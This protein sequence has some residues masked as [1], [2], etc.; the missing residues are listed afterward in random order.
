MIHKDSITLPESYQRD[1]E[2]SLKKVLRI[3]GKFSWASFQ[4]LSVARRD[5]QYYVFDG[6]HRLA[7]ALRRSD[8]DLVPCLVFDSYSESEEAKMFIGL[9]TDRKAMDGA[10]RHKALVVQGDEI[11][12]KID[13]MVVAAGRRVSRTASKNTVRCVTNMRKMM[14]LDEESFV[15]VW[16]VIVDVCDGHPLHQAIAEGLFYIQRTTSAFYLPKWTSRAL[17]SGYATLLEGAKQGAAYLGAGGGKSW[18]DGILKVLNKGVR[19]KLELP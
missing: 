8:I 4:C 16:P 2:R 15:T 13:R 17:D 18:A 12:I 3:A 6:G 10:D 14:Q 7:A 5:G 11:A 19:N 1:P 9:N